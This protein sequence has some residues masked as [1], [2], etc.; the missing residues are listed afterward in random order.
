MTSVFLFSS[1][2][3]DEDL[4]IGTWNMDLS[5]ST[6]DGVSWSSLG[7]SKVQYSFFEDGLYF[8]NWNYRGTPGSNYSIYSISD[9]YLIL[10]GFQYTIEQLS[11]KKLVIK[12][13]SLGGTLYEVFYKE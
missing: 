6:N 13:S 2:Q 1:C 10:D 4:I 8:E 3:K 7:Y 11:S 9:K 5:T 12:K